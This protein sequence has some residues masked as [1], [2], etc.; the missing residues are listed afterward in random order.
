MY[1]KMVLYMQKIIQRDNKM[2]MFKKLLNFH[3]QIILF[4]F[5]FLLSFLSVKN[6]NTHYEQ[7]T[8]KINSKHEKIA[9]EA[10]IDSFPMNGN[11]GISTT[12]R[13]TKCSVKDFEGLRFLME[14]PDTH[15]II[16]YGD[17]VSLHGTLTEAVGASNP[18]SFDYKEYLKS[19]NISGIFSSDTTDIKIIKRCP[20]ILRK[21]FSIRETFMETSD[22][23]LTSEPSG[24]LKAIV[25]GDRTDISAEDEDAFKKSGVYHIVAISGLHLSIFICAAY[26]AIRKLKLKRKCKALL[27]VA[28]CFAIGLFVLVFTGFGVSLIRAF[29][30]SAILSCASLIPRHYSSKNALF[31]TGFTMIIFMPFCF[32]STSFS[33]SFLSTLGVLVAFDFI[34]YLKQREILPILCETYVGTTFCV[35]VFASL[36]TLPVTVVAFG[37][38]PLLSWIANVLILPV[39]PIFLGTGAVFAALS[40]FAPLWML[41]LISDFL[42]GIYAYMSCV[43]RSV[44]YVDE[45]ILTVYPHTVAYFFTVL[46]SFMALSKM[47][48]K[49]GAKK[50]FCALLIFTVALGGFLVYNNRDTKKCEIIFADVGQGDCTLIT[51]GKTSI[52]IDS[53][54]GKD[55]GYNTSS[56]E[57]ML[58]HKNIKKIDTAIVTHYH[59]DHSNIMERLLENG[60]IRK[61]ILPKYYDPTESEAEETKNRLITSALSSNVEITYAKSGTKIDFGNDRTIEF[62]LPENHMYFDNNNM[63]LA[64]KFVYGENTVLFC[65]DAQ[66][67]E[68]DELLSFDTNCDILKIPH[69]GGYSKN[70]HKLIEKSS[71]EYAVISCSKYNVY[72]HPD[73]RVIDLLNEEKIKT[74]G[75]DISGAIIFTMDKEKIIDVKEMR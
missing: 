75:T 52:M 20:Y 11:G 39:M 17:T 67:N 54:T 51:S 13:I 48:F 38:I 18:G 44:A 22:K 8:E 25:G 57:A 43:T 49:Y 5:L 61:L 35:S 31:I 63:S 1:K 27:S 30:M 72:N 14:F 24:V 45:A 55:A 15:L 47:Y 23:M 70:I 53:G 36:F 66:E 3:S 69:H 41:N 65:G 64:A 73:K 29:I 28:S 10:V 4:L 21:I 62:L 19:I 58:R 16:R 33:L 71:P 26:E 60:M 50:A 74:K 7:N 12:G 37:Y 56:V 6:Y 40:G 32:Y 2:N 68:I 46:I 9:I 42:S 59:T 34:K